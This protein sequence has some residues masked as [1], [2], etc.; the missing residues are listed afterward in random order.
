MK[1]ILSMVAI[2]AMMLALCAGALAVEN[3]TLD[4]QWRNDPQK[5][6]ELF[7]D[8]NGGIAQDSSGFPNSGDAVV[9]VRK[10]IESAGKENEF[11]VTLDVSTTQDVRLISSTKTDAAMMLILDVSSSMN[12]CVDCGSTRSH[13]T[14]GYDHAFK[15][16]L[17]AMKES[18]ETLIEQ[19][20]SMG[21][22]IGGSRYLAIVTYSS[23][24]NTRLD[25]VDVSDPTQKTRAIEIINGLGTSTGTNI[26]AGLMLGANVW[27]HS[28]VNGIDYKYTI[29]I[30]DGTPTK[31]VSTQ[32]TTSRDEIA[33]S[34]SIGTSQNTVKDVGKEA[35]RI[36]AKGTL[37]KLYSICIGEAA[38]DDKP[39]D[40]WSQADPATTDE[41][42]VF[43]W[44]SLFSTKAFKAIDTTELLGSFQSITSQILLA[45]QAWK[46]DDVMGE[47]VIFGG[48][49]STPGHYNKYTFEDG[50]LHWDVLG[51]VAKKI[52][53]LQPSGV[54]LDYSLTYKVTLDN[55]DTQ[56]DNLTDPWTHANHE[57]KLT[58]AVYENENGLWSDARE[59]EFP[60]PQVQGYKG[61]LEFTKVYLDG[62]VPQPVPG[63]GFRLV[64]M[65][66]A[67]PESRTWQSGVVTSGPDGKVTFKGIP[68]GHRY[69]L[70]EIDAASAGFAALN[71]IVV[72][73][74]LGKATASE[75][76]GGQ[77]LNE[78][79]DKEVTLTLKKDFHEDSQKKPDSVT[80][81]VTRSDGASNTVRLPQNSKWETTIS[82]LEPGSYTIT[83]SA[84]M[85]GYDLTIT[86]AT[87]QAGNGEKTNLNVSSGS[88]QAQL[89]LD[90]GESHQAYTVAFENK[91]TQIVSGPVTIE[92][93]FQERENLDADDE[94]EL[95][96]LDEN[97]YKDLTVKVEFSNAQNTATVTLNEGNDWS[98]TLD[99][100]PVGTYTVRETITGGANGDGKIADHEF[101][102]LLLKKNGVEVTGN[103][104]TIERGTGLT[105]ELGN[106][107]L[108]HVGD[109]RVVKEFQ[110]IA[111]GAVPEDK[112]FRVGVYP[113]YT[114]SA[115][116]YTPVGEPETTIEI[117]KGEG[118][119][120]VG[121]SAEIEV[122]EYLLSEITEDIEIDGYTFKSFGFDNQLVTV[123]H[124]TTPAYATLTNVYEQDLGTITVEKAWNAPN[125]LAKPAEIHVY[126]YNE[127]NQLVDTLELK[128]ESNYT[129]TTISLP[130]G[131]Y[132][133]VEET[134]VNT[135]TSDYKT[136]DVPGYGH[137]YTW[138]NNPAAISKTTKSVTATVTNSYTPEYGVLT[139]EKK[140]EGLPSDIQ[141]TLDINFL[142]TQPDGQGY[143]VV[144]TLEMNKTSGWSET[145]HLPA[146]TYYLLERGAQTGAGTGYS[147]EKLSMTV[148]SVTTDLTLE[149]MLE[150]GASFEVTI[151]QASEGERHP[152]IEITA[153]NHYSKDVGKLTI[154]KAFGQN[155]DLDEDD[156]ANRSID[157]LLYKD[158]VTRIDQKATLNA[159]NRWTHT[160]EN[161]EAGNYLLVEVRYKDATLPDGTLLNSAYTEGYEL[162]HIWEG[163][164]EVNLAKDSEITKTVTNTYTR[165]TG[166]LVIYKR[167]V[168]LPSDRWPAEVSV[169][170]LDENGKSVAESP[171]TINSNSWSAEVTLPVGTYTLEEIPAAVSD[172]TT[173]T[174]TFKVDMVGTSVG[175]KEET[176]NQIQ[177]EV[178]KGTTPG[179]YVYLTNNYTRKTGSLT[180]KKTVDS[181]V[182]SDLDREFTFRVSLNERV[183]GTF[184]GVEFTDGVSES[185]TL[186]HGQSRTITGLPAGAGYTV[187]ETAD[188]LFSTTHTGSSGTISDNSPAE[189]I[190]T[191]TRVSNGSI[192][193]SKQLVSDHPAD[194][195][196]EF[197]IEIALSANVNG[198]YS[199][200]QFTQG[201][202]TIL[203][204]GGDSKTITDLPTGLGYTVTEKE[205]DAFTATYTGN[206]GVIPTQGTAA[207]T[208]TNT[209]KTGGLTVTKTVV[210][211]VNGDNEKK[212]S[213]TVTL[214]PAISGTFGVDEFTNGVTTFE[215]AHGE[216]KTITG[217]PTGIAYTVTETQDDLFTTTVAGETGV[218][219]ELGATAAFTNTRVSNGSIV[220]SKQ[221]VSDHPA[222]ADT[223][224]EIEIALSANVNGTYSDVQFTQGKAT[225]LLKGGESKTITGLPNGLGY[226]V[227]E[228]ANDAFNVTYENQTGT[229]PAQ[230]ETGVAAKIINT[231]R[232]TSLTIRKTVE[233]D[234]EADKE[235]K[236][237]FEVNLNADIDKAFG[238]VAFEDGK[239]TFEL[240]HGEEKVIPGLP[241]G[242]TYTVMET[243]ENGFAT[244]INGTLVESGNPGV[245]AVLDLDHQKNVIEFVN[246][247]QLSG[248]NDPLVI[249][250]KVNSTISSDLTKAFEFSIELSDPT[251]SGTYATKNAKGEEGEIVFSEGKAIVTLRNGESISITGLPIGVTCKVTETPVT[252][253]ATIVNAE[254]SNELTQVL[255]G[256]G[257]VFNFV[258]E[259]AIGDD[260]LTI[261]KKLITPLKSDHMKEFEF[262]VELTDKTISGTFEAV[263][264]SGAGSKTLMIEFV[265]GL[266]VYQMRGGETLTIKGLPIGMGYTVTE[267]NAQGFTTETEN[268]SG[269]INKD[270]AAV[271]VFTNTRVVGKQTLTVSKAVTGSACSWDDVFTFEVRVPDLKDG[272]Y[273]DMTFAGGMATVQLKH[274]EKA[275]A[276]GIPVG[277][278]Y[279]VTE[280]DYGNY[281]PDVLEHE[282]ML[283]AQGAEAAFVNKLDKP[284]LPA[285]GDGSQIA[286]WCVALALA[287]AGIVLLKRKRA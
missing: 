264:A 177:I 200:V 138:T 266:A 96:D 283:T 279:T 121:R 20:A 236:F 250:K 235:L 65:D 254:A 183:N 153:T 180:V 104:V 110:G 5:G 101:I 219:T 126:V 176:K 255:A 217:L 158:G 147:F 206:E 170:V 159:G 127:K 282:G 222:D 241:F 284:I 35:R 280:V 33:G 123:T 91:Y 103:Q 26:E 68:S 54:Q 79:L 137:S 140:F 148:G 191:N 24:A 13:G 7:Y 80:F 131:K 186:K 53:S 70:Q 86:G 30:S 251:V 90:A 179:V 87:I 124:G 194:A 22:D 129:D 120:W 169:N 112:I 52:T 149:D 114:G 220:V 130:V 237:K 214:D 107:Y 88:V 78:K 69:I 27:D 71:D 245:Q 84:A 246:I 243:R 6:V 151:P 36:L 167:F 19:Y 226:T 58:Y 182:D 185:F 281:T 181:P 218:I 111:A 28:S 62:N 106:H 252:G 168:D 92:K 189:A 195:D 277:V 188:A 210:G 43:Q 41:M 72:T 29:M 139:L 208:I 11:N 60:Q 239:A 230:N 83:E 273:G 146:G 76:A 286:L 228:K 221:L 229:I 46:V 199:N 67:T 202:A 77:L 14:S 215:L 95:V 51:S 260:A 142:I 287:G 115:G 56:Y 17:A 268:T 47:H 259:R 44:M 64:S 18:A 66:S 50:T 190:F 98:A 122:G 238:D 12:Y 163:G 10:S 161:L 55:L 211:G 63:M 82:G 175:D 207:A 99:T 204:K 193:V 94:P 105:L 285:T 155:S 184:D 113:N 48:E 258:N 256:G 31:Y 141:E 261:S 21:S 223:E 198:M 125:T 4:G 233:S 38:N 109:I 57:A 128:S 93:K 249:S 136:A 3:L 205:N 61:K 196:T 165:E 242:L 100:L 8:K 73:V 74:S 81:T 267:T 271:A 263:H 32:D 85:D 171:I 156:F 227:T 276:R 178:K 154:H 234:F 278:A 203:L 116:S 2:L 213:F 269:M 144:D 59:V 274:G 117:R 39:F 248:E 209:R 133:L 42:T 173:G 34:G 102:H 225:I 15:T 118:D 25:W 172:Y 108:H 23:N 132:Y 16:R 45:A 265:N 262:R 216:S 166:K 232:L 174:P 160:F 244:K 75:L 119:L 247:R 145:V 9:R 270:A 1:K 152:E 134:R 257:I 37:A 272:I 97:L 192:V 212:F 253:F 135:E 40:D 197:E 49:V 89:L 150:R 162:A 240:K 275:I 164:A 157:V 187:T 231:R 224:F 143:T 201:K